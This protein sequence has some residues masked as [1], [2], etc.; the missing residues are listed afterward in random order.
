MNLSYRKDENGKEML[1]DDDEKHQIMMEWEKPYME[2]SIETLEPFGKVLEIGFGMGYS[3][4]KICSFK[5]V[6]EYNVIE[7]SPIVW[8]KFEIFKEEQNKIRE[9]LVIKLIKGRWEDV[10]STISTY[11]CIYFDDYILD[12]NPS[13]QYYGS[14][15]LITFL[16]K[17]LSEHTKI[18]S[19]I[20]F[21]STSNN[22]NIFNIINCI[23]IR[24]DDYNIEIPVN[25]KYA[26]G[27]KMYIPIITKIAEAEDDLKDKLLGFKKEFEKQPEITDS[28]KKEMEKRTKYKKLFDDIKI[29]SPSCGLIIID[30]F[31]NNPYETRKYILTQE[32]LVRGNYPGQ[33]TISYANEHLKSIIQKYVEPFGGKITDFPIPKEDGSNASGIYNGSFQFTTSRDRSWVHIDGYNNWA[34]VL[35]MTPNA[36]L[37]AGTSFYVF[38]DG[39]SCKR[40]MDILENKDETD[41][42]SQ[43]LTKWKKV[44]EVGNV[45]NRLILFNSNRFH[46][47][48]DYF[49]DSKENGRLFQVFFFSTER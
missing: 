6:R 44:D 23:T 13:V 24:F 47:S 39:T 20:S 10:L 18:G 14:T 46:M 15:R 2:K 38:H 26:R 28:L 40:D 3:A 25:C 27:N 21:Y 33:R 35:Y 31:Y 32:F 42:C 43:D 17:I 9:E 5:E 19:K 45:F 29:R 1:C 8:E 4:R 7:C 49:G 11:D 34:G 41:R 30:N 37:T 36:P 48:M 12:D 16:Y 22:L